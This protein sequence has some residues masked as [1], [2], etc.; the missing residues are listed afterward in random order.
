M[1]YEVFKDKLFRQV[2]VNKDG[3]VDILEL[4]F[5]SSDTQRNVV[6]FEN[7]TEASD[8]IQ[9]KATIFIPRL[10]LDEDNPF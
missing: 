10:D 9:E 5:E 2:T 1:N 3:T 4:N 7:T 6:H 8:Y